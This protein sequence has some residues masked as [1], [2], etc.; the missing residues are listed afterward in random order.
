MTVQIPYERDIPADQPEPVASIEPPL[1]EVAADDAVAASVATEAAAEPT[2][3]IDPPTQG[4]TIEPF[5]RDVD[6]GA[7]QRRITMQ[8]YTRMMTD[9]RVL[10]GD[11]RVPTDDEINEAL[12]RA[13]RALGLP[14]RKQAPQARPETPAFAGPTD[15]DMRPRWNGVPSVRP[16][17]D[18]AVMWKT[19]DLGTA[20][21]GNRVT[22]GSAIGNE[23]PTFATK[24]E[25][26][27]T[28]IDG[29]SR[30][31]PGRSDDQ[32]F[33]TMTKLP[34]LP[35]GPNDKSD[36]TNI[37]PFDGNLIEPFL[38]STRR[39]KKAKELFEKKN[40]DEIISRYFVLEN[41]KYMTMDN[42]LRPEAE[43]TLKNSLKLL[44]MTNTGRRII[45]NMASQ[46]VRQ[47]I[48]LSPVGDTEAV[49]GKGSDVLFNFRQ[50]YESEDFPQD[51]S[52]TYRNAIALAHEL[53]HS[54]LG[55]SDPVKSI[56]VKGP[57]MEVFT[58][59]PRATQKVILDTV[60]P[61]T[62]G[63]N[64][65]YIENAIRKELR[66]PAR[67]TYLRERTWRRFHDAYARG[68]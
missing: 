42:P 60:V 41:S 27:P 18:R 20:A 21:P 47:R 45:L 26:Y 6:D 55:Y 43:K 25:L 61:N 40:L 38:P 37:I 12:N 50:V 16:D 30:G 66:I 49:A 48:V 15:D 2:D 19:A 67:E 35:L 63:D 39:M 14:F 56:N 54:I 53:G 51:T 52:R 36:Q 32:T 22:F 23:I 11:Q 28:S 31:Q 3:P 13:A 1:P 7:A 33:E 57:D 34:D 65:R 10:T 62:M 29:S 5:R 64:V 58:N 68:L 59:L 17:T 4:D 9:L 44:L 24:A 8:L 46:G